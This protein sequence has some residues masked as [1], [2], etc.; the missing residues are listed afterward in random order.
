M[1]LIDFEAGAWQEKKH[2]C[3]KAG[4]QDETDCDSPTSRLPFRVSLLAATHFD[5]FPSDFYHSFLHYN[6]SENSP[7]FVIP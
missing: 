1:P 3:G 2:P 6:V 5:F 4:M 7:V